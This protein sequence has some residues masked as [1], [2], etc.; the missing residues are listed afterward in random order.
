MC[1]ADGNSA[2]KPGSY[3]TFIFLL[4][5]WKPIKHKLCTFSCYVG[6][7]CENCVLAFQSQ[8]V[9]VLPWVFWHDCSAGVPLPDLAIPGLNPSQLKAARD[10]QYVTWVDFCPETSQCSFKQSKASK[11][12]RI[13]SQ[14]TT[15]ALPWENSQYIVFCGCIWH[16][17][18]S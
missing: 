13:I 9:W 16:C 15:P 2:I 11:R 1:T 8:Q 14:G 7:I 12:E 5:L 18:V 4:I 10:A 17:T 6:W 3:L